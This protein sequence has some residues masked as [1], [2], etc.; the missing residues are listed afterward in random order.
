MFKNVEYYVNFGL[1]GNFFFNKRKKKER[2]ML[3]LVLE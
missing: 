2:V 3:L 1:W